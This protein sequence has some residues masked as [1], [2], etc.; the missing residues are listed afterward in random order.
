MKR[1]G[2]TRFDVVT[3]LFD[4][5]YQSLFLTDHH[6]IEKCRLVPA[7]RDNPLFLRQETNFAVFF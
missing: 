5:G 4:L 3:L 1:L 7:D 2:M 6:D